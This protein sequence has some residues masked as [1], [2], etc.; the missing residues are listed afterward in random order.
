MTRWSRFKLRR[1]PDRLLSR[2]RKGPLGY[3]EAAGWLAEGL[4]WVDGW[5]TSVSRETLSVA[6]EAAGERHEAKA[7][8]F[9]YSRPDLGDLPGAAGQ[10]LVLPAAALGGTAALGALDLH[11]EGCWYR[12]TGSRAMVVQGDLVERLAAKLTALAPETRGAL[13][14]FLTEECPATSAKDLEA[15]PVFQ[16]NLSILQRLTPEAE[17][18]DEVRAQDETGS[19]QVDRAEPAIELLPPFFAKPNEPVGLCIDRMIEVDPE[20]VFVRGWLWDVE[21]R[22]RTLDFVCPNHARMDF[23]DSLVRT[24]RPEIVEYYRP[25]YGGI[26]QRKHGFMGL[27]HPPAPI[28]GHE[29]Y[30]LEVELTAGGPL[31]M[32]FPRPT[33]DPLAGRDELLGCLPEEHIIDL[34]LLVKQI[35]PAL[36]RLRIRCRDKAA[37]N[38]TFEFGGPPASPRISL[39]IPLFKRLDLVEH[40]LA[41][42]ADDPD[43]ED[44]EILYVLDSPELESQF[45]KAAFHLSRLYQVPLRGV[46]LA[47][48][49]AYAGATNLGAAEARGRLLVLLHSD[50]FPDRPGWLRKL[51][52]F[53]DSQDNIGA[54]GTKLLYEDTSLQHAGIGFSRE[55]HPDRRWWPLEEFKGLPR[56]L[57]QANV[58]RRVAAVSSACLMIDRELFARLEGL[59]E[60]YVAGDLEDADLC[61]RCLEEGKE[62][63]YL[64]E[65]ELFHFERQSR[66]IEVGWQRNQWSELY[67]RWL[68]DRTWGDR[69]DELGAAPYGVPIQGRGGSPSGA[70][71]PK[72]GRAT[73]RS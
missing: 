53:Y 55:L 61:L 59:G 15:D 23:L 73:K 47:Q 11:L 42:L 2:L 50:V 13:F 60:T 67:N 27:V 52:E 8:R 66:L 45:E 7:L 51:A 71:C 25:V 1:Q 21:D 16:R 39:V 58:T 22:V 40:Q 56:T 26:A 41:Q 28:P 33:S 18:A 6:L 38:R 57:P 46:V 65:V 4:L 19:E 70:S 63:W 43:L 9:C 17:P 14:A 44:S 31:R 36:E 3:A 72:S 64:P 10:I 30:R 34:E 62:N 49:T 48:N 35:H 32:R 29:G 54:L 5:L 69:L 24:E 68:L 12:W 37:V 20:T